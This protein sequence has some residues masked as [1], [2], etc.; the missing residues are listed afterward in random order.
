MVLSRQWWWA[1]EGRLLI[2]LFVY[3]PLSCTERVVGPAAHQ[4]SGV[5]VGPLTIGAWLPLG[6]G[7]SDLALMT[8]DL[9]RDLGLNQ[10]EFFPRESIDPSAVGDWLADPNRD[11][12]SLVEV[13]AA[14]IQRNGLGLQ[15]PLFYE[16]WGFSHHDKLS[17]WATCNFP[18]AFVPAC[19]QD[20]AF[21]DT[22]QGIVQA[23][24]AQYEALNGDLAAVQGYLL[25]NEI[26]N[27]DYT[28]AFYPAMAAA[29]R[30]IRAEDPLRPAL[31]VAAVDDFTR[32]GGSAEGFMD[33]FFQGYDPPNIF[34]HEHYVFRGDV[35]VEGSEGQGGR[36]KVAQQLDLLLGGY[37]RVCRLVLSRAGRWHAIVQVHGEVRDGRVH[38]REPEPA[39]IR[40]Q[41]GLALSRGASGIVYFVYG[42]GDEVFGDGTIWSY[43]GLIDRLGVRGQRYQ[44]VKAI[45]Q[46]LHEIVEELAN[47]HFH[48]AMSWPAS[49]PENGLLRGVGGSELEFGFFGDGIRETHLLVVN[50]RTDRA[51]VVELSI[52]QEPVVDVATGERLLV[53]DFSE[54][55][56]G[57][58]RKLEIELQPGDFR[59]LRFE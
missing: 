4:L 16:P 56:F 57:A 50:R 14:F 17:N 20:P 36:R 45:N 59:L 31:A 13:V 51:Q 8:T 33:A 6:V 58:E 32:K 27:P 41:V 1:I 11:E 7:R 19:E 24:R 38:Y 18:G 48:R 28:P 12:F 40:V 10:V 37:D 9:E 34:Q 15:L 5:T 35:A 3:W 52:I 43:S 42:S 2:L 25:L 46:Y 26:D 21:I 39:E 30:A 47:L 49:M 22:V 55:K 23:L 44:A 53:V 29:I 54:R